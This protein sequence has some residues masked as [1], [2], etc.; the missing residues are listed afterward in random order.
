[1]TL[2]IPLIQGGCPRCPH[3][4]S[5]MPNLHATKS[6]LELQP[7]LAQ[8]WRQR[9]KGFYAGFVL[10]AGQKTAAVVWGW[11]RQAVC[12]WIPTPVP[13]AILSHSSEEWDL[14]CIQTCFWAW[15]RT[16]RKS[17][18]ATERENHAILHPTAKFCS[19]F[20]CPKLTNT[21][22]LSWK[23]LSSSP[24]SIPTVPQRNCIQIDIKNKKPDKKSLYASQPELTVILYSPQKNLDMRHIASMC[25]LFSNKR[26]EYETP[27]S[28]SKFCVRDEWDSAH[29]VHFQEY[30]L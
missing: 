29:T 13:R 25:S 10:L 27:A 19:C 16:Q 2:Q 14:C 6:L 15:Q 7:G 11:H 22:L 23:C 28:F 8:I 20:I 5:W 24:E 21:C 17:A 3:P 4:C 30:L 1:M 26:Q 18:Q 12:D 9:W